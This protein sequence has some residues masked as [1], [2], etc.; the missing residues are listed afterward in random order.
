MVR[1][2]LPTIDSLINRYKE[3][4]A[5]VITICHHGCPSACTVLHTFAG[6]VTICA[7]AGGP[8]A[9]TR[10]LHSSKGAGM[11]HPHITINGTAM[12][13]IYGRSVT[14]YGRLPWVS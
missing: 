1:Y 7:M 4:G 5:P 14:T 12:M 11:A 3:S 6:Q 9:P 8:V 13:R 10:G 2:R